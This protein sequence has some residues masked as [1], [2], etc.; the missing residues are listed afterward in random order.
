MSSDRT[1]AVTLLSIVVALLACIAPVRRALHVDQ[2]VAL[3][4]E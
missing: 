1:P 4:Y 2:T 3:K